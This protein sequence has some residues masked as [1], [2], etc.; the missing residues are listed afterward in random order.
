M[1]IKKI[2]VLGGTVFISRA[3]VR[4]LLSENHK[5]Y[6]L[7]RGTKP[8]EP[9]AV[10]L[11]ADRN[12]HKQMKA[13]LQNHAFDCVVDVSGRNGDQIKTVLDLIQWN[14]VGNYLL[15][16]SSAVYS[17]D[18]LSPPFRETDLLAENNIWKEYGRN[19]IGAEAVLTEKCR[20][21][22]WRFLIFR[23]PYIYG[24]GNNIY[25]ES[26]IFDHVREKR[27]IILPGDGE[28]EVQFIHIQDLVRTVAYL[29]WKL[30]VC[31]IYNVGNKGSVSFADWLTLCME[32]AGERTEV[33]HF[34][35][36][37]HGYTERNFFPFYNYRNILDIEKISYLCPAR[38]DMKC[39]LE[40][41]HCWYHSHKDLIENKEKYRAKEEEIYSLLGY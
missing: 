7:N 31:G 13:V 22:R 24:E 37:R 36:A 29:L 35:Y 1:S 26:F 12:D 4:S 8:G 21:K 28:T 3:I 30:E 33:I 38:I 10:P 14:G 27:P 32:A 25:R 16:S 20:E 2:L 23:P 41:A 18:S 6:T 19:K 5:V 15:I 39:G 34:D 11:K 17:V 40:L 9:G